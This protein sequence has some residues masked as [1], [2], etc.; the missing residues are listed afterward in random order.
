MEIRDNS[1]NET[2]ST[3]TKEIID[4]DYRIKLFLNIPTQDCALDEG[5]PNFI[6]FLKHSVNYFVFVYFF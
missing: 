5:K 3:K 2:F 4:E 1:S 6:I